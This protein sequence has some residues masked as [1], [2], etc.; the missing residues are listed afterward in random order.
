[1]CTKS[2]VVSVLVFILSLLPDAANAQASAGNQL[3]FAYRLSVKLCPE[4]PL[5]A[6][7]MQFHYTVDGF[8]GDRT[9]DKI[10]QSINP[11]T[12]SGTFEILLPRFY[13][14]HPISVTANCVK[15]GLIGKASNPAIVSNCDVLSLRDDDGDGLANSVE[16]ANCDNF[17]S[18]GDLSNPDNVDTDGDGVRD[19]VEV[20]N[21][22]NPNNPGSSPRP[23]VISGSPFDPD[24][25]G[26]SNPVVWR[27][28]SGTWFIRDFVNEGN[29]LS[30]QFGLSGD[31]PFTY[32]S[33]RAGDDVGVIRQIGND[34]FWLFH[35]PGFLK[36]NGT[37]VNELKFGLFGDNLILGPWEKPGVTS[38]AV[39][40][41][42]NG[43][44]SFYIY[45]SDGSVVEAIWGGN[46]D[47]PKVADYDGDGLFDLAV[48]RPSTATTYV[49]ESSTGSRRIWQFG[50]GTADHSF[51]GDIDG[52]GADDLTFWEP[53]YGTFSTMGKVDNFRLG[54]YMV[55]VPMSWNLRNGKVLYT[56]V[57]HSTGV[58]YFRVGNNPSSPLTAVP[59]GIPG[60]SHG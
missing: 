34:Y 16:D 59:W 39:A 48:F 42:F 21:G 41:L 43:K 19:L 14:T 7:D 35:G 47:I 18:P 50:T 25:D 15:S 8:G 60:D 4:Y 52:D 46:G 13:T 33:E 51:R 49:I 31:V 20:V 28:S 44:W 2:I 56:V 37:R 55:H 11:S 22:T 57:D 58:R 3:Y 24:S 32:Q 12:N 54:T 1:M 38:P 6:V 5:G 26:N 40:R 10:S 45:R 29:N 36:S 9:A 53:T 27:P 23:Y 17:Y 30:L